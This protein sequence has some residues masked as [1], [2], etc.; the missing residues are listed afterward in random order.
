MNRLQ[1][2]V[3]VI[4]VAGSGIGREAAALF[5]REGARLVLVVD[6]GRTI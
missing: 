1:D 3:A 4:V 5:A 2:E 6:G